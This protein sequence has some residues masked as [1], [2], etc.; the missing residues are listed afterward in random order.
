MAEAAAAH[1]VYP[2]TIST[3]LHTGNVDTEAVGDLAT[4]MSKMLAVGMPLREVVRAATETPARA[5]RREGRLGSLR[6]GAVGDA[7][8]FRVEEAGG[9]TKPDSFGNRRKLRQ[10]LVPVAAFVG[11]E[12]VLCSD[13]KK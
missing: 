7:T 13:E 4:V 9:A 5:V 2:D 3:D 8:V 6:A 10:L 1:G 12:V 11:G